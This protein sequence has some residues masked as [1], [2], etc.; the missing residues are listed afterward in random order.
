VRLVP[1]VRRRAHREPRGGPEGLGCALR[2]TA[3]DGIRASIGIYTGDTPVPLF[4][5]YLNVVTFRTGRAH[6]RPAIPALID[7]VA[8]GRIHPERVTSQVVGWDDLPA[9]LPD[10]PRKLV[11]VRDEGAARAPRS[12]TA[13][14][15][16]GPGTT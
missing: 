8:G 5:M 16:N 15:P 6:A 9:A 12:A 1:G 10:P 4:E 14:S 2:S 13:T 3:P 7:L 11:A